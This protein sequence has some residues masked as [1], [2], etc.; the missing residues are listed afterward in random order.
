[1]MEVLRGFVNKFRQCEFIRCGL[2]DEVE[3]WGEDIPVMLLFARIGREIVENFD[4]T[5]LETRRWIFSLIEEGTSDPDLNLQNHVA[6]GLLEALD[7]SMKR[8][9]YAMGDEISCQLGK[10]SQ[11]YLVEWQKWSN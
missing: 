3:Y 9:G 6:T 8:D 7:G 1:M 5:P 10:Q 11:E 4:K 2:E